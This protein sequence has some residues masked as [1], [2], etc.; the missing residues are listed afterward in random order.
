MEILNK[1][2]Y[3]PETDMLGKG[4]FATVYKAY[5]KVL[6]MDVALKFFH[7]QDQANKYTII[8]E[9]KKAIVLSHPNIVKYYGIETLVNKNFH[10]QEEQ[11]Q[12]GVMEY[13]QEGQMKVFLS[14]HPVPMM[15]LSRLLIDVL[16]GLKYLHSQ[17]II[18]RDI[19]PQNILLGRDKQNKLIAKI[20][21]F[22]ISKAADANQA[23]A[24]LLLG[25]IEYMAPE[26]FNPEKYGINKKVGYNVDI[27][28]FGATA[29][30]LLTN[31]LLFGSRSGDTSAAHLI[32]KIVNLE[33]FEG[34][35]NKIEEPFRTFLSKCIVPNANERN[36][37]VDDLIAILKGGDYS[38]SKKTTAIGSKP[39]KAFSTAGDETNILPVNTKPSPVTSAGDE[40]RI[41]DNPVK[42][43][44]EG[45]SGD[46][47]ST[48]IVKKSNKK[49]K[50]IGIAA[51]LILISGA[52]YYLTA[53]KSDL[54]PAAAAATTLSKEE[55]RNLTLK[56]IDSSFIPVPGG[57]Y[58]MGS[59]DFE[60]ESP[61]HSVTIA[62]FRM[63]AFEV[64]RRMWKAVMN[65]NRYTSDSAQL[66]LPATNISWNDAQTF[67]SNLN[68]LTNK[69]YRLPTE[70]EWEYVS[71]RGEAPAI[72]LGEISWNVNTAKGVLHP[73]KT[74]KP[75]ANGFY[76]M[77]GNAYEWCED[78]FGR[79]TEKP[80]GKGKILRGGDFLNDIAF[81]S[82]KIRNMQAPDKSSES[83]GFRL[84]ADAQ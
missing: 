28:A 14:N 63:M 74:K 31:E 29:Y 25:T 7:P 38:K 37:D 83:I 82:S 80:D 24:S 53:G 40:T 26:Q 15:E 34:K 3:N 78:W 52:T 54:N 36:T 19:K 61:A 65:D 55:L 56:S 4:G 67:I 13:V 71:T 35:L 33:G 23:S 48:G 46:T 32:N 20:A 72:Q 17:G 2:V 76:D 51:A 59:N 75:D 22:G 11:V 27:W 6:E 43:L 5:D 1:Y 10:G 42:A 9:I 8:N 50:V 68:T 77:L 62:P 44:A 49:A 16:E 12:I 41:I 58:T 70:A 21:D 18:H 39:G 45:Y 81:V 84:A 73:V 47:N 30:Y 57:E 66:D 79:Y 64:T 69:R 60:N